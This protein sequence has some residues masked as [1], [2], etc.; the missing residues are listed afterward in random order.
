M[1]LFCDTESSFRILS[2]DFFERLGL[3]IEASKITMTSANQFT[4]FQ[5]VL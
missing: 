2:K 3:T 5:K 1:I 4:K